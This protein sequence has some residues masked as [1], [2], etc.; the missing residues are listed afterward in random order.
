MV[1]T[2]IITPNYNG[3][4]FLENY[5]ESLLNQ[6]YSEFKIIFIDNSKD[7]NSVDFI[8]E[9]YNDQLSNGRI[10]LIENPENYG[11]ARS[12]NIGF[13]KALQDDECNYLLCL[14]NDTKIKPNFLEEMLTCAKEHIN[15]GSIQ[16]KLI[17]GQYPK[18][19]D[20][21]GI[22][23][24]KNGLGFNRGAYESSDKY[25]KE[26]EIFGCCAAACLYRKDALTDIIIDNEF[27][28]EDFFAYYEDF[29]LA[30]RLRW[31]GWSSWY[32][33]NAIAYHYKGGTGGI[34]SDFTIYHNWRNYN[35][36][37]FKN[38]PQDYIIKHFYLIFINDL[39]Q[40]GITLARNRSSSAVKAK[41]DA[42]R[43][44]KKF[45]DKNKKINKRIEFEDLEKWFINKW[46]V[47]IPKYA[48][49]LNQNTV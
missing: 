1:E 18:L 38:L 7:T 46:R 4:E 5:F 42:Y 30:L 39:I 32:C 31:A 13:K 28:D 19:I 3:L 2:Y 35:W 11:F 20:S 15:A 40:I 12:N 16:A 44:I 45:L 34:V 22:E 24:S 17:W 29:D 33:P 49:F 41:I 48:K 14:N 6:S 8:K 43:N 27:F 25:N 21:V 36:T 10:I 23:Y 26:E 9:N 37:L 47:K